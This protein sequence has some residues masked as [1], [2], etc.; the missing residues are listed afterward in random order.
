[1]PAFALQ[2]HRAMTV[3]SEYRDVHILIFAVQVTVLALIYANVLMIK[4]V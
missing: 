1:M 2:V 4:I 3:S